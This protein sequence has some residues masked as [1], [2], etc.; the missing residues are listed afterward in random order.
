[1]RGVCRTRCQPGLVS[2]GMGLA[3]ERHPSVTLRADAD[4]ADTVV[5][6][7][8]VVSARGQHTVGTR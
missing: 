1:M 3:G 2:L 4:A 6:V 7:V 5:V 8:A